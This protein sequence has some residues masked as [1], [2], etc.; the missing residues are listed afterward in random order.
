MISIKKGKP[1]IVRIKNKGK[2]QRLDTFGT[3]S[4]LFGICV[5]NLQS[6]LVFNC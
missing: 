2:N 6:H 4:Q 5:P 3:P 1:L